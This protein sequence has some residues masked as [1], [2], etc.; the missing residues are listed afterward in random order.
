[1]DNKI[2]RGK[3]LVRKTKTKDG[4]QRLIITGVFIPNFDIDTIEDGD[5]VWISDLKVLEGG[6]KLKSGENKIS[7]TYNKSPEDFLEGN[8]M[9]AKS[10][11][12]KEA[13]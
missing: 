1:M 4:S 2:L 8:G 11:N 13:L 10:W 3:Y 5:E 9:D 12:I 7:P 6:I